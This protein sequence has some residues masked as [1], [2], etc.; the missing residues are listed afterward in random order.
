MDTS[1]RSLEAP[2]EPAGENA[3]PTGLVQSLRLRG[4]SR[5]RLRHHPFVASRH[6]P[7]Q[8]NLRRPLRVAVHRWV[9]AKSDRARALREAPLRVGA[10]FYTYRRDIS[11]LPARAVLLNTSYSKVSTGDPHPSRLSV[12][13]RISTSALLQW[14][15]PECN[16]HSGWCCMRLFRFTVLRFPNFCCLIQ[17]IAYFLLSARFTT[18]LSI[19]RL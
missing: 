3:A 7:Y 10:S 5:L 4:S 17:S 8:G 15:Y 11:R 6:F 16:L 18:A 1:K 12:F 19:R 14:N 9:C 2:T 13:E